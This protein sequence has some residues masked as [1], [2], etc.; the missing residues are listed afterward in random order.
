MHTL[1]LLGQTLDDLVHVFGLLPLRG[2]DGDGGS[3]HG[4]AWTSNSGRAGREKRE[5]FVVFWFINMYVV[6]M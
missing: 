1:F 4:W 5:L 2:G 6:C 3:G